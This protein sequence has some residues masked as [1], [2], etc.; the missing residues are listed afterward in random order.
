MVRINDKVILIDSGGS[1]SLNSNYDVGE[2]V[3]LPY[4]L[5]KKVLSLDYIMVSHFD[6]DH[7]EGFIAVLNAIKVKNII[8]SKQPKETE[9]YKKVIDIANKKRINLIYVKQGDIL[10][11]DKLKFII[12][13]PDDNFIGDQDLNNNA[14]VCKMVYNSFSMLFTGDIEDKGEKKLVSSLSNNAILKS[15]ILKVGH[16]G[17]KTSTTDEFLELV[18]PSIALIGVGEENK[19]GHPND[20]VIKKLKDKNIRIY[21]TDISGE[22]MINVSKN[23]DIKIKTK[24]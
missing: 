23:G 10:N 15:T 6:A 13:A 5:N 12:L 17:S 2:N 22:I 21:R 3:T 18:S 19:F 8:L 11:I 24:L 16:H 1:A 14:I 7:V 4:I 9:L 20:K